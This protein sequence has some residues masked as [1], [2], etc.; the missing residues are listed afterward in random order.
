MVK[1]GGTNKYLGFAVSFGLT[2]AITIYLLLKGGQWLDAKL[3]TAPVFM[4]LGVIL[5]IGAVFKRLFT[6]LR[7]LAAFDK[8]EE[9]SD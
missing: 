9:D 1:L 6:D 7:T 5:G 3:G 8:D 2:M 4:F